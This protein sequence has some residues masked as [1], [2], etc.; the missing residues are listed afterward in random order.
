MSKKIF[1]EKE[2]KLHSANN[3]VKSVSSKGITYT[4]QFKHI[5]IVEK[6]GQIR[7]RLFVAVCTILFSPPNM[8]LI[9]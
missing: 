3:Y 7:K 9:F 5:F 1:T 4:D 6:E 2:I 8:A